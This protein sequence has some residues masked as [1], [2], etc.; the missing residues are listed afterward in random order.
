MYMYLKMCLH[1]FPLCS[2]QKALAQSASQNAFPP[3]DGSV[4]FCAERTNLAAFCGGWGKVSLPAGKAG[5][6][7]VEIFHPHLY[8]P[9][10][11]GRSYVFLN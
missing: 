9:P 7:E 2:P 3:K 11:R 4:D 5:I 1:P 6:G 10:S 8:P